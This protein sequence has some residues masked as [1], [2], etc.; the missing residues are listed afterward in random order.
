MRKL[1]RTIAVFSPEYFESP[2]TAREWQAALSAY[3]S[4]ASGFAPARSRPC[5]PTSSTSTSS[6]Q[7]KRKRAR[8]I[9][10]V[11]EAPTGGGPAP[12]PGAP[13]QF[14][15][16]RQISIA[17]LPTVN[18]LLIGREAELKQL[19]DAWTDPKTNLV[20]IVA[21][22]GV[23]K[24]SLAIN[25]WHRNQAPGA[26]RILGWSFY[27]QGAAEDR[28]ASAEPFLDHAL[29]VWFGVTD[30]PIDSWAR[31]EKLAELIR[32]ER[33]LLILDGLEPIQFP[34]GPQMGHFKD[35]GMEALLRELSAHNPGL[36]V[37]TS[38]LPLTDLDGPG[39]LTIDLDNLTP[40]SGAQYLRTLGVQ[41]PD[42]ELQKASEDFDN[43][44]L[45]LTL[46]GN[47]LVKR[48]KGDIYKRDTIPTV[49][50]EHKQGAHARRVL[51]QYEALFKGKPELDV[52]RILGL[53]DRPADRGALKILR[54]MSPGAWA[55]ALENLKD[56]RLI[57]YEDLDGPLDCHPLIRE[58]FAE[59]Y[60]ASKPEAFR[61]AQSQLYEYYSKLA[62]PLP[63]TLEEMT[64]L[65]YAVYHGCQA[66]KHQEALKSVYRDRILR[67]DEY[68]LLKQLGAYGV[69]LSLLANFFVT[70]WSEPIRS[71]ETGD[72]AWLIAN[73]SFALRSFGRLREAVAP[74]QAA[75]ESYFNQQDWTNAAIG[76]GN[77]SELHLTLGDVGEAIETARRSVEAA[78]KSANENWRLANRARLANAL[79]QS[80][81][82]TASALFQAAEKMQAELQPEY[83]ILYSLRGYQYCDLL[84]T[85]GKSA[86]V[87]PPCDTDS[88]VGRATSGS[89]LVIALD[90]LSLG[91]AHAP[92]SAEASRHL[93]ESVRG[94]R[95]AGRLDYLPPASL[96][97]PLIS[98][99][100]EN[101]TKPSTISK[102]SVSSPPAAA[103]ASSS[104]TTTSNKPASCWPNK[105]PPTP[106]RTTKPP[107]S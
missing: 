67:G 6:A 33:T 19:D 11:S 59:E 98:A 52:L 102:K 88:S 101:G 57:E 53:F 79:H 8:L 95:H 50:D 49:L 93:D 9:N 41:G 107:G 90:H 75:I 14:P 2:F 24:T 26:K 78:D 29:R 35:P 81:D 86:E 62:P 10:G 15:G 21:F 63:D 64:P 25:W 66:G 100:P 58:H 94:L 34:P 45:A 28:Q 54:K 82:A 74:L 85:K 23:G 65:F 51:R 37:C 31:G 84:L 47:L 96:P 18:P 17:K 104:P 32:R 30:P 92:G 80:G 73:A 99:T 46:L 71:L 13:A 5:W 56:A 61:A 20:S 106:D 48:Y 97:E 40:E 42:E 16:P 60:R 83:L 76:L 43:H 77:L 91:C 27:S 1:Q 7:T 87:R 22:G 3:A 103:C 68:F 39:T 44:A 89:L 38:R 4:S 69:N 12:F 36:C 72:Q 105:N 70:P 55:E